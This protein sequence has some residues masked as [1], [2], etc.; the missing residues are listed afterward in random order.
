MKAAYTHFVCVLLLGLALRLPAQPE[1]SPRLLVKTSISSLLDILLPSAHIAVEYQWGPQ[2]SA[3]VEGGPILGIGHSASSNGYRF[4]A[5]LRKYPSARKNGRFFEIMYLQRILWAEV[6][7]DFEASP[8]ALQRAP[9]RYDTHNRKYGLVFTLGQ[10]YL[11][12]RFIAEYGFGL[13]IALRLQQ[14]N[15]L[16]E[17]AVYAGRGIVRT[18]T[19][20][21]P[22]PEH[23]QPEFSFYANFGYVAA[24][25]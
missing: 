7:N 13:G 5:A 14:N 2:W 10:R 25:R 19:E 18:I 11:K 24:R 9:I 6:E 23:W 22:Q 1:A 16:P 3:Q 8:G 17:S 21:W 20:P 4:R 12:N 15:G